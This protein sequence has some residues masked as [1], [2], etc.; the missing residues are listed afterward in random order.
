MEISQIICEE[1]DRLLKR[2][3][4]LTADSITHFI[5][6]LKQEHKHKR[7]HLYENE[8]KLNKLDME[9]EKQK[10]LK[11][12][13]RDE[14]YMN[15]LFKPQNKKYEL[16]LE[17]IVNTMYK[18]QSIKSAEYCMLLKS[19]TIANDMK[20]LEESNFALQKI[21]DFRRVKAVINRKHNRNVHDTVKYKIHNEVQKI[22]DEMRPSNVKDE[23]K[24]E[25]KKIEKEDKKDK[26][27][28]KENK[29]DKKIK[30]KENIMEI[31]REYA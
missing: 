1:M 12:K 22:R 25:D 2:N 26:K 14:K 4:E 21:C 16:E 30:K 5:G 15:T 7:L 19:K 27:I 13:E 20:G 28:E 9:N 31:K 29:K 10:D 18:L 6:M 24:T 11:V 3:M 8:L 23:Q 17:R